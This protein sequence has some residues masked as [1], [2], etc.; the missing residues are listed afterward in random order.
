[1]ARRS[2][3]NYFNAFIDMSTFA[4]EAAK[5]LN[6]TLRNYQNYN[7]YSKLEEIQEIEQNADNKRH[8]LIRHLTKEFITP[9]EREDIMEMIQK[10]DTVVDNIEDVTRYMYMFNIT[11]VS[12]YGLEFSELIVRCTASMKKA[13]E[14]F[15]DFRRNQEVRQYI[16]DV[17]TLEGEGDKIQ[18][19]ALHGIF[20][21]DT[22]PTDLIKWSKIIDCLE[23]CLDACEE[24]VDT[25]ERI[26]MKN[27]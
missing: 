9:I 15:S 26:I 20:A 3:Y 22:S 11:K 21:G 6:E 14:N 18:V 13:M 27:S 16:L 19:S 1:M 17:N 2:G 25:V 7:I 23:S 5:H 10:L 8:E 12:D 4:Y 24:V